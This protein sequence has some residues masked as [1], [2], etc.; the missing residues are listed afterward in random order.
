MIH[1]Q[2]NASGQADERMDRQSR[3]YWTLPATARGPKYLAFSYN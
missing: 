2:E 3:P 1:F